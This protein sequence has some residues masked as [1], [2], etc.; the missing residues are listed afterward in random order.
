ME[1]V[2]IYLDGMK[3]V[4]AH[5][6]RYD[7]INITGILKDANGEPV[8]LTGTRVLLAVEDSQKSTLYEANITNAIQGRI[9]AIIQPDVSGRCG[10]TAKVSTIGGRDLYSFFLGALTVH[11]ETEA[12]AGKTITSLT[13]DLIQA[14]DEALDAAEYAYSIEQLTIVVDRF[15]NLPETGKDNAIYIVRDTNN[16]YRWNINQY[17]CIGRDYNN[18]Q[19]INGGNASE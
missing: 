19:C 14:R 6:A 5:V 16:I 12:S 10:I 9:S 17:V 15:F 3:P 1:L 13:E 7:T 18:I 8:N 4:R 11:V 2:A